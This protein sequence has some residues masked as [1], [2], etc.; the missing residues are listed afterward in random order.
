M[1]VWE[2][3]TDRLIQQQ[4]TFGRLE[5]VNRP[6]LLTIADIIIILSQ[7]IYYTLFEQFVILLWRG[8]IVEEIIEWYVNKSASRLYV[9]APQVE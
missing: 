1:A 9:Y 2:H 3:L 6:D 4:A 8:F 5:K 7:P